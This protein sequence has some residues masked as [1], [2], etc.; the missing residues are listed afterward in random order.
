MEDARSDDDQDVR[1]VLSTFPVPSE[2]ADAVLSCFASLTFSSCSSSASVSSSSHHDPERLCS[3]EEGEMRT[4]I[5]F[6]SSCVLLKTWRRRRSADSNINSRNAR[7]N[8]G[9]FL[10]KSSSSRVSGALVLLCSKKDTGSYFWQR[11]PHLLWWTATARRS[12][13]VCTEQFCGT[14]RSPS[15]HRTVA[16]QF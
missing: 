7:E 9:D 1:D 11:L 5:T 12:R 3:Q 6:C 2:Y 13:R 14:E 8:A 16:S 10:C 15:L 4:E